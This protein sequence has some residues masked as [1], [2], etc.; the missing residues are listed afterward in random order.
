MEKTKSI[1]A[2][3]FLALAALL[4]LLCSSAEAATLKLTCSA[5]DTIGNAVKKL[6]PGDTLLVSG[7]CSE[8]VEIPVEV[9]RI[10]LDGQG[11]TTI[12]GPDAT[13]NAVTIRGR[14]ILLKFA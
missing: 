4:W 8:N 13:K 3:F 12:N 7:N 1:P 6:K 2:K 11:K 5:K 14:G 9:A 10:T